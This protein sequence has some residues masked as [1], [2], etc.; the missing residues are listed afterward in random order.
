MKA[1][2]GVTPRGVSALVAARERVARAPTRGEVGVTAGM[3]SHSWAE[4]AAQVA[5]EVTT[6]TAPIRETMTVYATFGDVVGVLN[7]ACGC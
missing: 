4:A 6:G 2:S 3:A 5:V 1:A 7:A